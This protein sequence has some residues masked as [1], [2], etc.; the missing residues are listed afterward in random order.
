MTSSSSELL[1][2]PGPLPY[3]FRVS[4][5]CSYPVGTLFKAVKAMSVRLQKKPELA[6]TSHHTAKLSNRINWVSQFTES[7]LSQC[8]ENDWMSFWNSDYIKRR[9]K[10]KRLKD[11][12][13]AT[14]N[15][16][17]GSKIKRL[18]IES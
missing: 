17:Q 9:R 18:R 4:V 16:I 1:I 3:P 6:I 2:I 15:R 12:L 13:F 10:T 7:C 14:K 5:T 11:Q 8:A